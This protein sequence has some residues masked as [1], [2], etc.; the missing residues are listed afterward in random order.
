MD[1]LSKMTVTS[2]EAFEKEMT[3][4]AGYFKE[5]NLGERKDPCTLVDRHGRIL[6]W[7][8]PYILIRDRLVISTHK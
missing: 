2:E 7:H 4:L 8:L 6:I 3:R 5:Q 1:K